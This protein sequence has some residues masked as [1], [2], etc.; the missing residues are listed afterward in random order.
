MPAGAYSSKLVLPRMIA[1][2]AR[3]FATM[4]ASFGGLS[5]A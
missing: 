1:P 2:A 5:L 3:S 4:V